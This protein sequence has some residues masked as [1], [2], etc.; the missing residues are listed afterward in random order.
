MP[1]FPQAKVLENVYQR[2]FDGDFNFISILMEIYQNYRTALFVAS[3]VE[4]DFFTGLETNLKPSLYKNTIIF[5]KKTLACII[6]FSS[7]IFMQL[8]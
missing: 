1:I 2:E 4:T 8:N 6:F 5:K 3:S 7:I